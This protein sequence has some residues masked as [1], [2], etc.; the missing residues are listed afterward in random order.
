M[1]ARPV[2]TETKLSRVSLRIM[3]DNH[4]IPM[5]PSGVTEKI[6]ITENVKVHPKVDYCVAD[7]DLKAGEA[8][9]EHLYFKG[10][11]PL[12]SIQRVFSAGLLGEKDNRKLVPTRWTITAVDDIEINTVEGLVKNI[13]SQEV[14]QEI[15]ISYW[16]GNSQHTTYATLVEMPE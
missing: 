1:A 7:T 2:D 8:V 5:G 12:S 10:K 11:V 13:R 6:R 4:F 16:R 3:M 14:G 9:A 15:K